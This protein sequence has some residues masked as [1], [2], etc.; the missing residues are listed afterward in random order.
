MITNPILPIWLML[1]I[2]LIY[3]VLTPFNKT[4]IIIKVALVIVL[5]IINIRPMIPNDEIKTISSNLDVLFVVDNSI[6]MQAEDM[7]NNNTRINAVIKDINSLMKMLPGSRYSLIVS[8]VVSKVRVPYTYDGNIIKQHL[9]TM[10]PPSKKFAMYQSLDLPIESIR[11]QLNSSLEDE[12]RRQVLFYFSDG[13]SHTTY[14]ASLYR[15]LNAF[16]SAGAIIG[17]GTSSGGPMKDYEIKDPSDPYYYFVDK[18]TNEKAL[19][20]INESNLKDIAYNLSLDYINQK[21]SGKIKS[22]AYEIKA[23]VFKTNEGTN[24]DT[25][26][27]KDT[28]FYFVLIFIIILVIDYLRYK[29]SI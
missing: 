7:E 27:Y 2:S 9:K 17:Y 6:S 10:L 15:D 20:M 14:D 25:K 19:S 1:I 12:T 8:D 26:Y 16:I 18:I 21:D 28:Y 29:R 23:G 3:L 11:E 4:S 13:E 5:N 22:K 24:L